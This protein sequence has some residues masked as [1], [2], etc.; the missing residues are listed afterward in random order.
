MK[1]I[2]A[3]LFFVFLITNG[4][5]QYDKTVFQRFTVIDS[6]RSKGLYAACDILGFNRNNEYFN[7]IVEG[8][9]LFGYHFSP[10]LMYVP[11][12]N[13]QI[14]AGGFFHNDFGR[15]GFAEIAPLLRLQLQF[16]SLTMVFGSLYGHLH[17]QLPE[18]LYDFERLLNNRTQEGAQFIYSKNHFYA[19]SWIE[20]EHQIYEGDSAQ[21]QIFAGISAL[22]KLYKTPYFYVELP[23]HLTV[24]H[25]GGQIDISEAPLTTVINAATGLSAYYQFNENS[26]LQSIET[27]NYFLIY[28]DLSSETVDVFESGT[29]T[30]SQLLFGF[31]WFKTGISYWFGDEFISTHGNGLFQSRTTSLQHTGYVEPER[32]LLFLHFSK[33]LHITPSATLSLIFEPFWNLTTGGKMEYS[34]GL[35]INFSQQFL[36]SQIKK[37]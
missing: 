20:W 7:K 4:F 33:E 16:D 32:E 13:M 25:K 18:P 12:K 5:S 35:Y 34:H 9:T 6:T 27:K 26:F 21:E 2:A 15:E 22:T 37:T 8:Y 28:N 30:Y 31:K 19:H 1:K 23:V 17:H 11:N 24:L 36:L 29:A 14:E 3:L 10:S